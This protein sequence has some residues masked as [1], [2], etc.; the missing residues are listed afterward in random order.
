M[1]AGQPERVQSARCLSFLRVGGDL[2][3][4]AGLKHPSAHHRKEVEHGGGFALPTTSFPIEL[5]WVRVLSAARGGKSIRLC[6]PLVEA[7]RA[8]GIFATSRSGNA[9]MHR[10]LE[11]LGFLRAGGEWPSGQNP[12]Q[13]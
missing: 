10:T 6:T 11:K 7:V 1:A 2:H 3:G 5:G 12:A 8:E 4:V 9:P 13:L